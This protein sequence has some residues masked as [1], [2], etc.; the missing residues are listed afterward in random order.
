MWTGPPGMKGMQE[1]PTPAVQSPDN[2]AELEQKPA[3]KQALTGAGVAAPPRP[4][5]LL[6]AALGRADVIQTLLASTDYSVPTQPFTD[7]R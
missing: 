7:H 6:A 1:P 3:A 2:S 4:P 5:L